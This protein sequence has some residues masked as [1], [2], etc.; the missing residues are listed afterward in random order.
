M[1]YIH[2]HPDWP[3]FTWDDATL[4]EPLARAR[5][6]QGRL[7]GRMESIGFD[8]REGAGLDMQTAELVKSWAIEGE[9]LDPAE[10][11]SSLA[12]QLGLETA[13]LPQTGRELDGIVEMMLDATR[14]AAAPLTRE[15][16]FAWHAALFP[17]GWSHLRRVTAGAWRS[18]EVGAMQVVSGAIGRERVHFEAPAAERVEGEMAAFIEWFEAGPQLDPLLKAGIAHLWLVTIHPFEDG[19]GRIARAVCDMALARA[20]RTQQRFYSLSS[21]LETER[22]HYYFQLESTQKAGLDITAWLAWFLELF[23]RAIES[24]KGVL[25]ETHA[26]ARFWQAAGTRPLNERQ[27][28][29]LIRLLDHFQGPLTTKKYAKMTACSHDTALRDIKQLVEWGLLAKNDAGGR[30]T[31]YH[32]V[33][34]H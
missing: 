12:K 30:S 16:L 33:A 2:E 6:E 14:N 9:S 21:Q 5:H 17:T 8:L 22:K 15:R 32:V 10:V 23:E 11:R 25:E 3:R 13:G 29:V 28:K 31:N 1:P 4:G 7:L 20:D 34:E 19:N 24:A 18:P 27:R 26:K